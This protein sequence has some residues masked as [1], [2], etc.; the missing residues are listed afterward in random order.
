MKARFINLHIIKGARVFPIMEKEKIKR[1][2][3]SSKTYQK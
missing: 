2:L 3:V 1:N